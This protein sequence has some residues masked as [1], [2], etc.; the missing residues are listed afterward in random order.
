MAH[1]RVWHLTDAP[2]FVRDV[3]FEGDDPPHHHRT[4]FAYKKVKP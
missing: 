4:Q 1:V 3:R 2:R